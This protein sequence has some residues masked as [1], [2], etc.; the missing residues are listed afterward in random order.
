MQ[1]GQNEVQITFLSWVRTDVAFTAQPQ[2]QVFRV[3]NVSVRLCAVLIPPAQIT[4]KIQ[5]LKENVTD[6]V[7]SWWLFTK[8]AWG[9]VHCM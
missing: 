3:T 4:L 1:A 8:S 5:L 7:G 6:F 9:D 2:L